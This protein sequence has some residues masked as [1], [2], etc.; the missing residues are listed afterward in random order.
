[1]CAQHF[2]SEGFGQTGGYTGFSAFQLVLL[3]HL[4]RDHDDGNVIDNGVGAYLPAQF[5]SIDS[6][7]GSVYDDQVGN[8]VHGRLKSFVAVCGKAQVALA[9]EYGADEVGHVIVVFDDQQMW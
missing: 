3:G 5:Q 9:G 8:A 1:M 7:D 2:G 4:C 6:L